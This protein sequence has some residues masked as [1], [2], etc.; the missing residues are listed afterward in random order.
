[1]VYG[2]NL[3]N[4]L[5]LDPSIFDGIVLYEK[6][7]REIC[8]NEIEKRCLSVPVN[9][10]YPALFKKFV[11]HFFNK[12]YN[13]FRE[14][15]ETMLY[16]Y[17]PIENYDRYED[18]DRTV[19][20]SENSSR[21]QINNSESK[22]SAMNSSDYQPDKKVTDNGNDSFSG[23][24]NGKDKYTSHIHGNIGVTTSQ[25][26]IEAQRKLVRYDF[27]EEVA[28]RFEDELCVSNYATY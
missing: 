22:I 17:N 20:S 25:Q 21:T 10:D 3:Y 14:L 11:H 6:I 4:M 18:S 24:G 1:M 5:Q 15:Y 13:I 27:Y 2:Y 16:E 8:I 9:C 28:K 7:D 26:M 23:T 19:D 12:N